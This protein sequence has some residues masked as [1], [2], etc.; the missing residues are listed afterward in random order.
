[1]Y[2]C[3]LGGGGLRFHLWRDVWAGVHISAGLAMLAG[4]DEH[5]FVFERRSGMEVSGAVF[6]S[7][8]FRPEVSVGWRI[9]RGLSL[10]LVPV[11][12]D[13]TFPAADFTDDIKQIIRVHVALGTQW[14]W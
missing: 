9:W 11:A 13:Y 14:Q 6:S 4:L 5:S 7:F 8:M 10:L 1:M 2:L 12:L 3:V